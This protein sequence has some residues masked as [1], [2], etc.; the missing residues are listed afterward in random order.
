[1]NASNIN[2]D[3]SIG[4]GNIDFT[5]GNFSISA[6]HIDFTTGNFTINAS[7][8]DFTGYTFRVNASNI[9][10]DTSIGAGNIDFTTGNYSISAGKIDFTTGNFHIDAS[11]ITIT[12]NGTEVAIIENGKI[13]ASL[14]DVTNL[15]VLGALTG[16]TID[17]Q[18]ATF[19]N[20]HVSGEVTGI[21]TAEQL[22]QNLNMGQATENYKLTM[23]NGD[24]VLISETNIATLQDYIGEIF[25]YIGENQDIPRTV[26][27]VEYYGNQNTDIFYVGSSGQTIYIP[28]PELSEGRT[29]EIYNGTGGSFT[30]ASSAAQPC[31]S[32]EEAWGSPRS[33]LFFYATRTSASAG[34]IS[35]NAVYMKLHA[36]K[37]VESG[38]SVEKLYWI[39]LERRNADGTIYFP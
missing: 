12:D 38:S 22:F 16:Q 6:G 18:N 28:N 9:N 10:F 34:D 5:T 20:L 11:H 1:M 21:V 35:T 29:I 25:D 27:K 14:I 2:F 33:D 24:E 32:A 19:Q 13:K 36:G 8:I 15:N 23:D 26:V 39:I 4:A 30:L 17:M 3:T 31:T 37:R 7:H